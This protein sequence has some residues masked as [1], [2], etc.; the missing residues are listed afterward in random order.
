MSQNGSRRLLRL[1]HTPV[2]QWILFTQ[3]HSFASKMLSICLAVQLYESY[4]L[5]PGSTIG[6]QYGMKCETRV[7]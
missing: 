4:I 5:Q 1:L 2:L 3:Q 6:Y 7:D